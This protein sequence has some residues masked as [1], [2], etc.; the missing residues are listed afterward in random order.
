MNFDKKSRNIII[1]V[2]CVFLI[3][4]QFLPTLS[5]SYTN[6]DSP[7]HFANALFMVNDKPVNYPFDIFHYRFDSRFLLSAHATVAADAYLPLPPTYLFL[8]TP[9]FIV[10][11]PMKA[12]LFMYLITAIFSG[13]SAFIIY[14]WV[15]LET[16][17][18]SA[19]MISAIIFGILP[20]GYIYF[21][22]GDFPQ[23]MGNFFLLLS[24]YCV[25]IWFNKITTKFDFT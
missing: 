24:V 20:V 17:N 25:R 13:L 3:L 22:G 2:I 5:S 15:K 16:D 6:S 9:F 7:A 14:K 18:D 21:M 11:P 19:G 10:F 8:L 4:L 12:L 1:S 23:I